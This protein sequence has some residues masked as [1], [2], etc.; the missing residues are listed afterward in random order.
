MVRVIRGEKESV[1]IG[2]EKVEV[3]SS[4]EFYGEGKENEVLEKD[5]GFSLVLVVG[6]EV[7]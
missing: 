5:V 2:I 6:G 1:V 4:F 7:G 3:V